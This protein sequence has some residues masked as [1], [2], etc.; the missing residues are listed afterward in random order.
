MNCCVYVQDSGP[1]DRSVQQRWRF[2]AGCRRQCQSDGRVNTHIT[3]RCTVFIAVDCCNYVTA[4]TALLHNY[5]VG[6]LNFLLFVKP[7]I[8]VNCRYYS[9]TGMTKQMC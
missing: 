1:V 4:S 6:V 9:G 3:V 2:Q 8:I 5:E 7:D